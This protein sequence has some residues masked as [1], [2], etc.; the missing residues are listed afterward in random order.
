MQGGFCWNPVQL[1]R[2][3]TPAMQLG[4][5]RSP[6]WI[7]PAGSM[8]GME[9]HETAWNPVSHFSDSR[10]VCVCVCVCVCAGTCI[11]AVILYAS[12]QYITS[13]YS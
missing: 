2:S 11:Y 1:R 7:L 12:L 13:I 4:I 6:P 9:D 10:R 8:D 5:A 3:L